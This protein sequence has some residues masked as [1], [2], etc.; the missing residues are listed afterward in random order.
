MV[1][2]AI[3]RPAGDAVES[4]LLGVLLKVGLDEGVGQLAHAIVRRRR[5]G[6]RTVRAVAPEDREPDDQGQQEVAH[7]RIIG[8]R[9]SN[10]RG[11]GAIRPGRR[12]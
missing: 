5:G 1:G 7:A 2:Q 9:R 8:M 12:V 4:R 10:G 3:V 6:G 11:A